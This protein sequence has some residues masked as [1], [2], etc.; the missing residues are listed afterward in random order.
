MPFITYGGR[1]YGQNQ[2]RMYLSGGVCTWLEYREHPEHPIPLEFDVGPNLR[3]SSMTY[4]EELGY[5]EL[6]ALN[7]TDTGEIRRKHVPL[8]ARE[9]RSMLVIRAFCTTG[10]FDDAEY[11]DDVYDE[12]L[13]EK[14]ADL[15]RYVAGKG[16]GVIH[17]NLV[18]WFYPYDVLNHIHPNTSVDVTCYRISWLNV[19]VL[20]NIRRAYIDQFKYLVRDACRVTRR[21]WQSIT[22]SKRDIDYIEKCTEYWNLCMKAGKKLYWDWFAQ[23]ERTK[24]RGK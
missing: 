15:S 10:I 2:F 13:D 17:C 22:L 7:V 8:T 16:N 1:V 5:S 9:L 6:T 23:R 14:I 11:P 12:D 21:D 3:A 24:S 19:R 18:L 4:T 20:C